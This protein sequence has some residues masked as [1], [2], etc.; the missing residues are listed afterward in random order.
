VGTTGGFTW[1]KAIPDVT[2]Q[3]YTLLCKSEGGFSFAEEAQ[4]QVCCGLSCKDPLYI[5]IYIYIYIPIYTC[6][7]IKYFSF[8]VVFIVLGIEPE[9]RACTTTDVHR[10][11]KLTSRRQSDP[12]KGMAPMSPLPS[13]GSEQLLSLHLQGGFLLFSGLGWPE[14]PCNIFDTFSFDR[15]I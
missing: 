3:S 2:I 5:G 14:T 15:C 7:Y 13:G 8:S 10:L 11:P 6:I 1:G 4:S 12:G 9:P